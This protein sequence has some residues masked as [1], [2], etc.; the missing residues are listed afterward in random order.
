M[1]H[2]AIIVGTVPMTPVVTTALLVHDVALKLGN[3]CQ[4]RHA[5]EGKV[6]GHPC[7]SSRSICTSEVN[8]TFHHGLPI[9]RRPSRLVPMD[10]VAARELGNHGN[11]ITARDPGHDRPLHRNAL[12][13]DYKKGDPDACNTAGG[14]DY[15]A[16]S[17]R[18]QRGDRNCCVSTPIQFEA[19][20]D[21]FRSWVWCAGLRRKLVWP[22]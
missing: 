17:I 14:G 7:V 9:I 1:V 18:P 10:R 20:R 13:A 2:R 21:P 15:Q 22:P 16:R 8:G 5:A 6:A 4:H 19:V 11:S 3:G 12:V